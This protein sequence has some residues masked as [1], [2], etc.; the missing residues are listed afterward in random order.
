MAITLIVQK[1]H[2]RYGIVDERGFGWEWFDAFEELKQCA[3]TLY[4]G[5]QFKYR[6]LIENEDGRLL[7]EYH[8]LKTDVDW[9]M[10]ALSL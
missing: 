7:P 2:A 8:D 1:F 3:D 5:Y 6:L 10:A 9:V 4:L